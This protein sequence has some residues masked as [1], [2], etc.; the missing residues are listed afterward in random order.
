MIKRKLATWA[1]LPA[2]MALM[3]ASTAC[4]Q[5]ATYETFMATPDGTMFTVNN[6]W[7][8]IAAGLVFIMHLGFSCV[9]T[10]LTQSKNTVNILF[11]NVFIV[12]MGVVTYALWGFNSMYPGD[13][14]GFFALGSPIPNSFGEADI[15]ANMTSSY[16]DYTYWSDFIFQAIHCFGNPVGHTAN[17]AHR[18]IDGF[19][20]LGL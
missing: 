6:L 13:F 12:C 20:R 7:L 5:E 2:L 16:A 14:N 8:L 18:Q 15:V 3:A 9:E 11:K 19:L 4:A 10:G 17:R 1:F